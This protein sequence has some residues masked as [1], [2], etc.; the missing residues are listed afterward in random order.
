MSRLIARLPEVPI[1]S[2]QTTELYLQPTTLTAISKRTASH[3]TPATKGVPPNRKLIRGSAANGYRT[4]LAWP[5]AGC[6]HS[7]VNGEGSL[8]PTAGPCTD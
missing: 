5:G 3:A 6:L 4:A 2:R 1:T 8:H 7:A